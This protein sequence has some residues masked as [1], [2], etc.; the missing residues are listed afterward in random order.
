MRIDVDAILNIFTCLNKIVERW[1]TEDAR[2]KR[3]TYNTFYEPIS[4]EEL[5]CWYICFC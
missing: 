3:I 1:Q 4:I 2:L 5:I